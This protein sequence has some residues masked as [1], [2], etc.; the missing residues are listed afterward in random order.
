MGKPEKPKLESN[1]AKQKKRAEK[2][3]EF[4]QKRLGTSFSIMIERMPKPEPADKDNPKPT[5]MISRSARGTDDRN[6]FFVF[7]DPVILKETNAH[8]MRVLA[9]HEIIHAILWDIEDSQDPTV[10]EN[11]TYILQ[12][13]IIGEMKN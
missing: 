5:M 6:L 3:I 13:A 7:A 12:R 10:S 2:A 4:A 8:N 1:W 11:A 9:I